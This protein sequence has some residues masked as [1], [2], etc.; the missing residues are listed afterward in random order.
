MALNQ[1]EQSNAK[2]TNAAGQYLGYALQTKRFL[3]KLLDFDLGWT[4]S[5]EVFEDVGGEG[6]A[7][8]KVAEQDK[9]TQDDNPVSDRAVELWKTFAN[10]VDAVNFRKLPLNNTVFEL[11]VSRPKSGDIVKSFA[12]AKSLSEAKCTLNNA[13]QKLWGTAP[14]FPLRSTVSQTIAPYVTKVFDA[15]ESVVCQIIKNF[16]LECGSGSSNAD[17]RV[18]LSKKFIPEEII[19]DAL[20]YALGWVKT[21]TDTLLEKGEPARIS[22]AEFRAVMESFVRRHDRTAILVTFAGDP[23]KDEIETHLKI[24]TYVRQLEIIDSED[25]E[26]LKAVSDFLRAAV[27]RTKWSQKGWVNASSFE[28]FEDALLRAWGNLK[29]KTNIALA[30]CPPVEKGKYLYA[31]CSSHQAKLQGLEVPPHFVPGSFH[32]LADILAVG[33]HPDYKTQLKSNACEAPTV[34]DSK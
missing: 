17:L 2:S 12:S 20:D 3:A 13:K 26:K 9:S 16:T 21:Q 32:V 25:G 24:K 19:D 10:W 4:V 33:W 22:V 27:D 15:D 1:P 7:G 11:F 34:A 18:M 31:E 8:C 14:T 28:E 30:S 29:T 23:N 5:L 6:P